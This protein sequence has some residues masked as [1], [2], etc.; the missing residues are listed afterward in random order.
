[1]DLV[2]MSVID[3]DLASKEESLIDKESYVFDTKITVSPVSVS[4]ANLSDNVGRQ[5]PFLEAV[6]ASI[7]PYVV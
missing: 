7:V 2:I 3:Q 1:M 6:Q 5:I 4:R